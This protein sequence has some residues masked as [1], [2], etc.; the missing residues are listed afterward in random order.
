LPFAEVFPAAEVVGIDVG[1]PVLR[2]A[3]ARAVALGL[4]NVSF[5]QMNAEAPDYPADQFDLVFSAMFLHETSSQAMPRIFREAHRILARGGLML[6]LE[7]PAFD[8]PMDLIEQ[9]MREWDCYYNSEPFWHTLN[10][11]KLPDEFVGAGFARDDLVR[12]GLDAWG[13]G[14]MVVGAPMATAAA[15]RKRPT[16]TISGAWKR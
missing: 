12:F 10:D 9:C 16:W 1:A 2:Y 5:A 11:T 15:A 3:H 7:L 14:G 13:P 4:D 8:E 6:H